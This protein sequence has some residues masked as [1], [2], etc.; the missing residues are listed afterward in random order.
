MGIRLDLSDP[1]YV[2]ESDMKSSGVIPG[3]IQL[4]PNGK[5]IILMQDGQTVGGYPRIAKILDIYLGRVAQVPP[6]GIIR[7]KK[8]EEF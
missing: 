4:P 5:P 3:I 1:L 2:Q 8:S 6:N 7:F